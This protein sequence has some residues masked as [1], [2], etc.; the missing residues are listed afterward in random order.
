M[1]SVMGITLT[2]LFHV[3][4]R[5]RLL[6]AILM[7]VVLLSSYTGTLP[8]PLAHYKDTIDTLS[9]LILGL[10]LVHMDPKRELTE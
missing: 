10:N 5:K 2:T 7:G 9:Y 1:V 8:A 3:E 6:T 4:N